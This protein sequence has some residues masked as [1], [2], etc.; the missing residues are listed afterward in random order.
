MA[1]ALAGVLSLPPCLLVLGV[2][3]LL[4]LASSWSSSLSSSLDL[5]LR[6][7]SLDAANTPLY[8]SRPSFVIFSSYYGHPASV[9]CLYI[10]FSVYICICM[11]PV[12]APCRGRLARHGTSILFLVLFL[13]RSY[14]P[15][16][17]VYIIRH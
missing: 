9:S 6:S 15:S 12:L 3:G 1:E 14:R 11:C 10:Y 16:L 17:S 8:Q 2:I 5:H 7:S 4:L 13:S